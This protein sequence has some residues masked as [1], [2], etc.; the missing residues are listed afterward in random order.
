[1]YQIVYVHYLQNVSPVLKLCQHHELHETVL[2]KTFPF[3]T[4]S[5]YKWKYLMV[6]FD[7]A[8]KPNSL[9]TVK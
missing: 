4:I 2:T 8:I 7:E 1:M 6:N 3:N 9:C 5:K